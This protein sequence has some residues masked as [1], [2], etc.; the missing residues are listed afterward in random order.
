MTLLSEEILWLS[1]NNQHL[2]APMDSI[3]QIAKNVCG[4]QVQYF[5]N[6]VHALKLRY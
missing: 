2:L 1:L 3:K 5:H 6:A 4:I